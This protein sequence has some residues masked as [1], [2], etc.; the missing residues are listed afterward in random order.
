MKNVKEMKNA[1]GKKAQIVKDEAIEEIAVF[2]EMK[3][4]KIIPTTYK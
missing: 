1:K 2:A 4:E 3:A